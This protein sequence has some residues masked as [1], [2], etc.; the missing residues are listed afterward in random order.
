MPQEPIE[1]YEPP[2]HAFDYRVTQIY[3]D[4]V[5]PPAVPGEVARMELRV[6]RADADQAIEIAVARTDIGR[7]L[8]EEWLENDVETR[9]N[10]WHVIHSWIR[11][12]EGW[13]HQ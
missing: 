6:D 7:I 5:I 10:E 9:K 8:L 11:T 12:A 3:G 1:P 13:R 2:A 4:N